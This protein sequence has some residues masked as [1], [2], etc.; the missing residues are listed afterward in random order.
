M[1]CVSLGECISKAANLM[2]EYR[3]RSWPVKEGKKVIGM[4]AAFKLCEK[5]KADYPIKGIMTPHPITLDLRDKVSK[6]K[7]IMLRRKI[8]HLPITEEGKLKGVLTSSLLLYYLLPSQKIS[9]IT[10]EKIKRLDYPIK[11]ISLE[12]PKTCN[13]ND[14][15]SKVVKEILS[16]RASYS[17]VTLWDEIQGIVT[18]RD[19]ISL[20]EE[21]KSKN[22]KSYIIGLPSDPFESE[23]VKIK[24]ERSINFFSK[25]FPNLLEARALIKP[26][27]GKGYEVSISMSTTS[28][29]YN[30]SERGYELS[31]IFDKILA[32]IKKLPIKEKRDRKS[33]R[34]KV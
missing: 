24:F 16:K 27:K 18:L 10:D 9:E 21:K 5:V 23:V 15:I 29:L 19:I 2:G 13:V 22:L 8:D 26:F 28:N 1:P 34:K 33:Y 7:S 14:S 17:I 31:E 6:A 25:I 11:R 12:D 32:K 3:L 4:I 20:L 30:F